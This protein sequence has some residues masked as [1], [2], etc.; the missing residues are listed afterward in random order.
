MGA[1]M[2]V[3]VVFVKRLKFKPSLEPSPKNETGRCLRLFPE[4]EIETF[5]SHTTPM[6]YPPKV[7]VMLLAS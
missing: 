3:L 5:I 7:E 6:F 4:L 1:Q 2:K